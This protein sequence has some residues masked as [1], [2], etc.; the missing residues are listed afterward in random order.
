MKKFFAMAIVLC[1][2]TTS[3]AAML[4]NPE[5]FDSYADGTV[6]WTG[7][8]PVDGWEGWGSGSGAAGWS[9][10]ND[11]ATVSN[12]T[13]T[14][15]TVVISSKGGEYWGYGLL[16][17]HGT[18]IWDIPFGPV[19]GTVILGFDVLSIV[20]D[21]VA[22]IEFYDAANT[23]L[24]VHAW[25]PVDLSALGHFSFSA[26]IPAGTIYVTPV[27]GVTGVDAVGVFD[28]ISLNIP[29]PASLLLLAFGGLLIRKRK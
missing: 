19:P 14:D 25:D 18:G 21:G 20:G 7:S 3:I 16:F 6:L 29:E 10:G 26:P 9:G 13:G 2:V 28:N 24:A 27:I 22:K 1:V 4:N 8:A 11:T 23:Q 5:T 17:N 12:P 15:G